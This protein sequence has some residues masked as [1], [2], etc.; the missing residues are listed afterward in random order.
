MISFDVCVKA[1]RRHETPK[2]L[3]IFM[4]GM[5]VSDINH[6]TTLDLHHFWVQSMTTIHDIM[7]T[8]YDDT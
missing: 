4:Q 1:R 7:T 2:I 3:Y 6:M 8:S 5:P